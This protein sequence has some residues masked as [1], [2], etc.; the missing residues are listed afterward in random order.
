MN[1][2]GSFFLIM[3]RFSSFFAQ[4]K[5]LKIIGA[6][7]RFLYKII[8]NYI[9]GI[10]ISDQTIIGKNFQLFHGQGLIVHRDTI[11][12]DNV[13]LR[14]NTTIGSSFEGGGA[15]RIGNFVNIGANCV[16]IGNVKIGDNSTIGAG[17]V[18]VKDV[19][20]NTTVVGN[21]A[22]VIKS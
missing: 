8:I 11:I 16:I 7:I 2:K 18:V 10:D 5:V 1:T 21:P 12:G 3:F 6:P 13:I 4:N 15:P 9:M 22:R 19:L 20:E 17:S 14:Q